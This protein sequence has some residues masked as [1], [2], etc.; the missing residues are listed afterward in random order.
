MLIKNKGSWKIAYADFITA[1]MILFLI[2]WITSSTPKEELKE[3]SNYFNSNQDK[4]SDKKNGQNKDDYY[5]NHTRFNNDSV[6]QKNRLND[7]R[8]KNKEILSNILQN[9]KNSNLSK[10]YSDLIKV[11]WD[12]AVIIEIVDT[13]NRSIFKDLSCELNQHALPLLRKIVNILQ[14][15][16]R[17]ITIDGHATILPSSKIDGWQ[18]SF[19]RANKIREYMDKY[20]SKGQIIKVSGNNDNDMLEKHDRSN[21]NNMRITI[22]LIAHDA[23]KKQQKILP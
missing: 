20:L 8:D 5:K 12:D 10:E 6:E 21:P 17:H 22:T 1:Q 7:I 19:K 23:L 3:I 13:N 11:Y 9:I 16:N 18:L 2:L 4:F 15:Q 14:Y